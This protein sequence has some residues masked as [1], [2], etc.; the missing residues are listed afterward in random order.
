MA[1]LRYRKHFSVFLS[2]YRNMS[3]G[4]GEQEMLWEHESQAS[5][6]T[7]L[8]RVLPNFHVHLITLNFLVCLITEYFHLIFSL[9]T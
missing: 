6:S 5:V 4:L 7:Q 2:S 3:G 9:R 8:F 1:Y